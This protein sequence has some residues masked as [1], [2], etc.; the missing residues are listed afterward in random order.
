MGKCKK[1]LKATKRGGIRSKKNRRNKSSKLVKFSIMDTN[2]AGLK[3]KKDSLKE[4]IKLFNLPS[5]ITIQE[6]KNRKCAN[7][8][9][10]NYQIFEKIR[11]GFGG[12][13][14]T[15]VNTSLEPVLIQSINDEV[16]ILLV[17]CNI[18]QRNIRIINGYGPQEDDPINKKI[19]FWQSLEQEI[20]ASKNANCLTLIQM[21][22]NA[23]LGKNVLKEDPHE[24][25]ENGKLLRG[26]LER[27][28]LELLNSS[29]LCKGAI[30]RHRVTKN[31][32]EKSILDYIL[33]CKKLADF[34]ELMFIDEERNFPLTKYSTTKGIKKDSEK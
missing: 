26:L 17:Q 27:E 30:T 23:K 8:K 5:V 21:D 22:G 25:T 2:A 33:T 15:A 9:L 16:E 14:L 31:K 24:I 11:S 20:S 18:G 6:T 3:A 29:D 4:N 32:E 7:F 10:E 34:L 12:G 19:R 1:F 13:L 28:S